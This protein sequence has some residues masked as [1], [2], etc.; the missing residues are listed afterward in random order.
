MRTSSARGSSACT[1]SR[2]PARGGSATYTRS[3]AVPVSSSPSCASVPRT[4]CSGASV[5][6]GTSRTFAAVS[7]VTST[8]V[9]PHS[10]ASSPK[11]TASGAPL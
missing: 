5:A 8:I 11:S 6:I 2:S 4:V 9:T 1:S 7:A 10:L 3:H